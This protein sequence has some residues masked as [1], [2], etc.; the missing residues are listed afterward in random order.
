MNNSPLIY[1]ASVSPRS[2][3]NYLGRLIGK[4]SSCALVSDGEDHFLAKSD[5][6]EIFAERV[7]SHWSSKWTLKKEN[8]SGDIMNGIGKG[9]VGFLRDQVVNEKDKCGDCNYTVVTKTPYPKNIHLFRELFQ[10]GFLVVL[11][12]DGRAVAESRMRTFDES[13]DEAVQGWRRGAREVI[14]FVQEYGWSSQ[15]HLT[16]RYEDVYRNSADELRRLFDLVGLDPSS[17]PYSDLEEVE[18]VGSSTYGRR[19]G[20]VTWEAKQDD[21]SFNPLNRFRDWG[22]E[23][24]E[25]FEWLAGDEHRKL[26]YTTT[27]PDV[28]PSVFRNY[29]LDATQ[30]PKNVKRATRDKLRNIVFS[31]VTG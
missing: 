14:Q 3:T 5:L 6:L 22:R 8:E 25:R 31:Y 19:D 16:L 1:I 30:I 29:L 21:G 9:L 27:K 24:H 17:Y 18:I 12:R 7:Y 10:A 23:K 28:S 2:G 4:H 11:I 26:R 13:F 15:R 20:D